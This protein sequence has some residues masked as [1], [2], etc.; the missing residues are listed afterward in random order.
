MTSSTTLQAVYPPPKKGLVRWG[1]LYGSSQEWLI[2]QT[3]TEFKGVIVLVTADTHTAHVLQSGLTFFNP[4]LKPR[5]FP[6][7]ETLPYD[8]FSPHEDII[9]ERLKTLAQLPDM[10]HDV[11]IVPVTTLMQRIA[12]VDYVRQHSLMSIWKSPAIATPVRSW[13]MANTRRAGHSSI[14]S[15]WAVP[16]RIV[17]TC[18]MMK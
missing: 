4:S 10:Q 5:I 8:L 9:S 6:D 1:Q 11:L 15:R 13:S 18:L 3:A 16:N 12:P 14:Y 7:W 2:T 17:L